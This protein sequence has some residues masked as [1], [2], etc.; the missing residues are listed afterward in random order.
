[1]DVDNSN[2]SSFL[3]VFT[4]DMSHRESKLSDGVNEPS[5]C[6]LRSLSELISDARFRKLKMML[7]K[8]KKHE[9]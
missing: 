1:L 7:E 6:L 4:L 5:F 2:D 3:S 8:A 9:S